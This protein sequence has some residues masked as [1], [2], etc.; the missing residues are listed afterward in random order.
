MRDSQSSSFRRTGRWVT[1]S[2]VAE[3]VVGCLVG[4]AILR[5]SP[6]KYTGIKRGSLAG[7]LI[8]ISSAPIGFVVGLILGAVF[9]AKK[10]KGRA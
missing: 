10:A 4:L 9:Q 6:D 7:L 5:R 3:I 8:L 1:L 2:A